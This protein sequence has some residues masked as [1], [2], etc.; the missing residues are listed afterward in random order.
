MCMKKVDDLEKDVR[1]MYS[2]MRRN[3]IH[4]YLRWLMIMQ[5]ATFVCFA[6]FLAISR[7]KD[8]IFDAVSL[9]ILATLSTITYVLKA[10]FK[11]LFLYVMPI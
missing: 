5:V 10:R 2:D 6:I 9:A 8:Y 3:Y 11:N 7:D 1:D 4:I